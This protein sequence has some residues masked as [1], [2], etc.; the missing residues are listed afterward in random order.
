[1]VPKRSYTMAESALLLTIV[2]LTVSNC[3][4][5]REVSPC[6]CKM[7][8]RN[9]IGITCMKSTSYDQ[10]ANKLSGHFTP[11]N[12]VYLKLAHSNLNDLNFRTFKELN[13]TIEHL[14]LEHD[15]IGLPMNE[16]SFDGLSSVKL[17][18]LSDSILNDVPEKILK[19]M[20]NIGTLT[21]DRT[22]IHS[23][24]SSNFKDLHHLTALLLGGNQI[25]RIDK[26]SIPATISKLHL[27]RNQLRHLNGT[28]SDLTDLC[29]L[30]VNANKLDS[31]EN[32]LPRVAP[33]FR[34]L[35]ASNNNLEKLPQQLK[36]FPNLESL[37]F[38]SN[39]LTSLDGALSKSRKLV[40]VFLADNRINT[41]TEDDFAETEMLESIIL[42]NN[43]L[44]TLNNSLTNL[45][46]LKY[47]NI[48]YNLLTEFSFQDIVGLEL[49]T[50][51]LSHNKIS[52]LIGPAANLVE[53]NIKLL[54]LKLDHNVLESLNGALSGLPLLRKLGLSYNRLKMISPDDLIGLDCLTVLDLSHNQLTTL[55]EMSKTFL[56]KLSQLIATHNNLTVLERDFHGLPVL[57]KADFEHNQII[58]LGRDL[59]AKT[60]CQ[61]ENN[62]VPEGT[63]D[64]LIMNLH[65]NPIICDAALP[66]IKS[67][68]EI[69]HTQI[70]GESKSCTTWNE[71]PTTIQ[72]NSLMDYTTVESETTRV[73]SFPASAFD[74]KP[75][76]LLNGPIL[77]KSNNLP[78]ATD[79]QVELRRNEQYTVEN[80][81][82]TTNNYIPEVPLA[83]QNTNIEF[84]ATVNEAPTTKINLSEMIIPTDE[85]RN[86]NIPIEQP[87]P[88]IE[89]ISA[90]QKK[91]SES[92]IESTLP[93]VE[94]QLNESLMVELTT[95]PPKHFPEDT[96][97]P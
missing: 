21:L 25:S 88:A 61:F 36:T 7:E 73:P 38:A 71:Q 10:V 74:A 46:K 81:Q 93:V 1:M 70:V 23:I 27:G 83:H 5:W 18:S 43:Q 85:I 9:V 63:W 94:Q 40:R 29:W 96:R 24:Q 66:E 62:N 92:E 69:N 79:V 77:Q 33:N 64:T 4:M 8:S 35:L 68:M 20:P 54:E 56:P 26:D 6:T 19:K 80:A 48:T 45:K 82:Q 41:I 75:L 13:M 53:W 72:P 32:E 58:S 47:L 3:P 42:S 97:K 14:R 55:E 95:L 49:D 59:V 57:C 91:Q 17:F 50:I 22:H 11:H 16:E 51:D 28:L 90:S 84:P 39:R 34:F 78:Y 52:K 2:G 76:P 44:T 30:F 37:F 12:R 60:R 15:V 86:I 65:D 67:L 89:L 31:L 87:P